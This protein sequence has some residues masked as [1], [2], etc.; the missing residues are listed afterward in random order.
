MTHQSNIIK[1]ILQVKADS[2][3]DS[4]PFSF[5]FRTATVFDVTCMSLKKVWAWVDDAAE[6]GCCDSHAVWM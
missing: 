1:L 6:S 3:T 5:K 4:G 2:F